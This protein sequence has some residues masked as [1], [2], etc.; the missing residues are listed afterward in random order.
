MALDKEKSEK[1]GVKKKRVCMYMDGYHRLRTNL[2]SV[3]R[4]ER[5]EG[6]KEGRFQV[7]RAGRTCLREECVTI[8]VDLSNHLK[9]PAGKNRGPENP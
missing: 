3:Q 4:R 2:K 7:G 8:R 9:V 5:K 6:T 1:V